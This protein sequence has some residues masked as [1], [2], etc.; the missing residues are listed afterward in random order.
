MVDDHE[1][2][3]TISGAKLE[4]A[5]LKYVEEDEGAKAEKESVCVCLS[6]RERERERER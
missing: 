3:L 4:R 6:E 1:E 5:R 2:N